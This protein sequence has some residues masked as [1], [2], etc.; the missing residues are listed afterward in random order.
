MKTLGISS[1]RLLRVRSKGD[2]FSGTATL[3]RCRPADPPAFPGIPP[4]PTEDGWP[5]SASCARTRAAPDGRCDPLQTAGF[6]GG[7]HSP[8]RSSPR[9][10]GGKRGEGWEGDRV[11]TVETGEFL[12]A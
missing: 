2:R 11:W 5:Q 3:A 1:E 12:R 10:S 7:L 6:P 8:T 9:R 4:E